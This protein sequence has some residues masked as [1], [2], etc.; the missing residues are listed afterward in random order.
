MRFQYLRDPLFLCCVAA[1]F[2]NRFALKPTCDW[3]F[4][5]S[6]LNDLI[7]IPFWVPIM[8]LL[9]RKL[10]LRDNDGSPASWEILVPLLMWSAVF[11][12]WVPH[13]RGFE[14]LATSDPFDVTAYAAGAFGAAIWW[15]MYYRRE[16][17]HGAREMRPSC[18]MSPDRG[19]IL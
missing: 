12:L 4:L 15:R 7:C 6:Y 3:P 5:H 13:V 11:E 19:G 9:M 1:Y 2:V 14:G 17:H 8:L 16:P 10:R 18:C